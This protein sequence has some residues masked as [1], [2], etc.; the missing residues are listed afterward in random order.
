MFLPFITSNLNLEIL[1]E[2]LVTFKRL[3]VVNNEKF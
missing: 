1:T 3:D 2:I